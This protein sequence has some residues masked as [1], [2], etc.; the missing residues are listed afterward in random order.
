MFFFVW[1]NDGGALQYV[2]LVLFLLQASLVAIPS[3]TQALQQHAFV[4]G[5]LGC[6]V[7]FAPVL[8]RLYRIRRDDG[9]SFGQIYHLIAQRLRVDMDSLVFVVLMV[10]SAVVAVRDLMSGSSPLTAG[11]YLHVAIGLVATSLIL[12]AATDDRARAQSG[13]TLSEI[14]TVVA[15]MPVE[16]YVPDTT[17]NYGK[18][19]ISQL[20]KMLELREACVPSTGNTSSATPRDFVERGELVD[21][22]RQCRKSND[23][24]IICFEEYNAGDPIRVLPKCGHEFHVEC[25][26]QWAY[27][28]AS[29]ANRHKQN[30]SC[31][32]CKV[33]LK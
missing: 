8:N 15:S 12:Q 26:D 24:C 21:A 11:L 1:T 16:E 14:I 28:C 32:L 18:C 33:A 23:S 31:P 19:S 20:K 17:D 9:L 6:F 2:G 30:P 10:L 4:L 29:S 27:T 13:T 3:L 25:I 5:I 7:G 22:V